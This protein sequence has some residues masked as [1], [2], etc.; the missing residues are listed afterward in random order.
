MRLSAEPKPLHLRLPLAETHRASQRVEEPAHHLL[1]L[2]IHGTP[3]LGTPIGHEASSW[4]NDD[5][6]HNGHYGGLQMTW[7]WLG[8]F[9]G[10]ANQYTQLQQENFAEEGYRDSGYS[11]A[12]LGGQ[13]EQTIGP[14][15]RYA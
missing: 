4:S 5:T 7:S 6:G 1:W 2:C 15:W 3:S 8:I 11:H 14:C 12:W 9:T 10:P 13:W